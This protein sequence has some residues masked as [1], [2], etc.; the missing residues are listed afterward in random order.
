MSVFEDAPTGYP[1]PTRAGTYWRRSVIWSSG[2]PGTPTWAWQTA[3]IYTGGQTGELMTDGY[4]V[5]EATYGWG[6][7]IEPPPEPRK[8]EQ[9]ALPT[10]AAQ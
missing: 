3:T 1:A 4:P 5:S 7:R 9:L 2:R 10:G 6:P 8:A